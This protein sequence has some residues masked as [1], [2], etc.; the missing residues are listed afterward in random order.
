MNNNRIEIKQI[1]TPWQ[2]YK[3]GAAASG[4]RFVDAVTCILYTDRQLN[5]AKTI[6]EILDVS[7]PILN[8][9]I[10]IS[11][12]VT[13]KELITYWRIWQALDLMDNNTKMSNEEV[14]QQCGF[15]HAH[16][17][18][19]LLMHRFHTTIS[20]Y[21]YG[22]A[23]RNG[24]YAYNQKNGGSRAIEENAQKLHNRYSIEETTI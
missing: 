10:K 4:D 6:A 7:L 5:E 2:L 19:V 9:V 21:R 15:A 18:G 11:T 24:N 17:L 20:A 1:T 16:D 22:E 13:L 8:G 23:R 14:A 12:G 3:S